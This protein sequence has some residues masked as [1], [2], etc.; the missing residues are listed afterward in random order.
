MKRLMDH[1]EM[2]KTT[3]SIIGTGCITE[4]FDASFSSNAQKPAL[5]FLRDGRVETELTY[6]NLDA[7]TNRMAGY[8][9]HTGI[10]KGDRVILFLPKS[11]TFL[12]AHLSLLR[13]GAVSV[14]VNP[15]FLKAEM[16]YLT[17]DTRPSL[18]VAGVTQAEVLNAVNPK[19]NRL[20]LDTDQPYAK[21]GFFRSFS[22]KRSPVDILPE[23][24]ATIIYTSG[25]TGQP[26]GAVLTQRNLVHDAQNIIDIW[27]INGSDRICHALPLF[28]V[29]GLG[30]ATHTALMAGAEI[31]MLD[32]FTPIQVLDTLARKDVNNACTVFM[33]VP[34]MYVKMLEAVGDKTPDF[35]HIRLWTSGSA[36]L[37][38]KDFERIKTVFGKAPVEREGM[39][40][41]GMNFSNP[42]D[43][44]RK[45]G[46]I[47]RPLPKLAVKIVSPETGATLKS[48]EI[49]EIWLK[50]PD[51]TPGYWE[52]PQETAKAFED[53]WFKTG[54]L[55]YVD[56][57]GY[58]YLT[59]RIKNII[60]S[61]GENISPKE[62]ETV[63]N[64]IDAV[65]ESSVVGLPDEKWGEKVVAAIKCRPGAKRDASEIRQHCR[66]HIHAW[67]TPKDVIFVEEIPKNRMGKVLTNDVRRLFTE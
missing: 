7:D 12:I 63:I 51:I 30:F 6:A 31:V 47:G 34:S 42:L 66:K 32:R 16:A 36:P 28:H 4:C 45:P 14:P 3:P 39:S 8:F 13:I 52:K 22:D 18:I 10:R 50:G 21:L 27:Q 40:E 58:Y 62:V 65:L 56:Q 67:K 20:I 25:T 59:D 61:G 60:I 46:S 41:T 55:G 57:D 33:A 54:D 38:S 5:R 43:G 9:S 49:G 15:G 48:G 19:L 26:K 35:E 1:E 37:L 44:P 53:S 64:Q 24:P 29:H 17:E 2:G 23:D 11:V